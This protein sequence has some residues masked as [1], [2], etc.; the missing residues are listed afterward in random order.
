MA[1][2]HASMSMRGTAGIEESSF[3]S[4]KKLIHFTPQTFWSAKKKGSEFLLN[5]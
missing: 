1:T 3:V 4:G 2:C 5:P